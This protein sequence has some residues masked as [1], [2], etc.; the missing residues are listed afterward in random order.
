[1]EKKL[2]ISKKVKYSL[3]AN[4]ASCG[5][6]LSGTCS[7]PLCYAAKSPVSL[8]GEGLYVAKNKN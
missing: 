1:M 7:D 8:K 2:K 5:Y 3:I 6:S 4:G